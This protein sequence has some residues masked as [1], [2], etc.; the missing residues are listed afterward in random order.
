MNFGMTILDKSME[1]EQNL[2]TQILIAL[3]FA[4]KSKIF[5]KIFSKRCFD[6]SNYVKIDKRPLPIGKN[7]KAPGLFKDELGEKI[8]IEVVPLKPK[9]YAYLM[10]GYS[11][12]DYE[13]NKVIN[14]RNKKAK[15][16]KKCIIKKKI[17]FE[18]YI[19]YFF[20]NKTIYR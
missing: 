10:D 18:N 7:K 5:L 12:D 8:M 9:T 13:K 19:D 17:M 15:G 20:N 6:T 2:V 3:L 14:P 1:T 16:T 11:N 4:L